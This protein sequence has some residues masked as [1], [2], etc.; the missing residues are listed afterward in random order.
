TAE[1]EVILA[2][3]RLLDAYLITPESDF[4]ELQQQLA[5]ARA[6]LAEAQRLAEQAEASSQTLT[7]P[8]QELQADLLAQNDEHLK[9]AKERQEI[10]KDLLEA[11]EL[12]AN[13]TL[14]AA[15]KQKEVN[16][17]EF[18][19]LQRLQEATIAGNEEAKHLLDVATQNDMA[20]VA[21]IYYRDY[22]DVA[23]D[24]RSS[25]AGGVGRHSD[26]ILADKYYREM[27]NHRQLQRLAQ[28]QANHFGEIRRT[29][30]AHLEELQKQQE[31]AAKRLQDINDEINRNQEQQEAKEQE[32]AV[33]QARLDGIARI[34][35]QTEQTFVQLVSLERLN[36]AQAQLEQEIAQRR[37]SEIDEA[38][39]ERL[40]REEIEIERQR[41]EARA[42]LEQLE[43]LQAEDE[44]QQAVN[45]VRA[46]VGLDA[47][48]GG[49]D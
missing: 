35:E 1:N 26:R 34:R 36:L 7:A 39:A 9:A 30:E 12:N 27:Q 32:L 20:T 31:D 8:L 37:Q 46:D 5:D 33:A 43:Q 28:Q 21:E 41:L 44:L 11:T 15:N 48:A 14:D 6:A 13:Y 19:V 38:V 10:L 18:Q 47:V 49:S 22:S 17:L 45:Q 42:K 24:K 16:D 2:E 29:A 40:E 25:S 3:Q 4:E 23:S